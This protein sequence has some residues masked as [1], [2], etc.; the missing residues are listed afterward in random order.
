MR[1]VSLGTLLLG[2]FVASL[3]VNALM[4]AHYRDSMST[5]AWWSLAEDLLRIHSVP[6]AVLL[7]GIFTHGKKQNS[8][9]GLLSAVAVM[10]CVVWCASIAMAWN[11]YG[12]REDVNA[13]GEDSVD[14]HL[15]KTSGNVSFLI[16]GMLAYVSASKTKETN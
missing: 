15:L 6:L 4:L 10:L 9:P 5:K 3:C 16:V 7:G 12:T 1:R 8:I 13:I 14:E 11:G 2:I